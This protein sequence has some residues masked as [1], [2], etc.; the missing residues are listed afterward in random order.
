MSYCLLVDAVSIISA[1]IPGLALLTLRAIRRSQVSEQE[2]MLTEGQRVLGWLIGGDLAR[3]AVKSEPALVLISFS[4]RPDAIMDALAQRVG[5][6]R[7]RTPVDADEALVTRF[8]RD[9]TRSQDRYARLQLPT[10]FVAGRPVYCARVTVD[11]SQR[12]KRRDLPFVRCR[13]SAESKTMMVMEDYDRE[14]LL[15][16]PGAR[17]AVTPVPPP[18]PSQKV[19]SVGP[20]RTGASPDAVE[21]GDVPRFPLPPK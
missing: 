3:G 8:L 15:S 14:D 7:G 5:D 20:Y 13:A 17:S 12:A 19:V 2:R 16:S 21:T 4:P 6:L 18:A 1:L 10:A 9:A 11:R